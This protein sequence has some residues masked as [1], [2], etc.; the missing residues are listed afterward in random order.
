MNEGKASQENRTDSFQI[1]LSSITTNHIAAYPQSVFSTLVWLRR[2][3]E[4]LA[5]AVLVEEPANRAQI[6]CTIAEHLRLRGDGEKQQILPILAQV[7]ECLASLQEQRA[8][9]RIQ[10][11]LVEELVWWQQWLPAQEIADSTSNFWGRAWTFG[12]I[13]RQRLQAG[14]WEEAL[15]AASSAGESGHRWMFCSLC[16]ALARAHAWDD[17]EEVTRL[18]NHPGS[19]VKALSV[20]ARELT[21]ASYV[22]RAQ[23]LWRQAVLTAFEGGADVLVFGELSEELARAH[24]WELA[25]SVA[26][27]LTFPL[28]G[29]D[30]RAKQSGRML[31]QRAHE[32]IDA[33]WVPVVR[34]RALA[35]LA[36]EYTKAQRRA[37][38]EALWEEARA[39]ASS[40][41]IAWYQAEALSNLA[42]CFAEAG[43]CEFALDTWRQADGARKEARAQRHR[44]E[45]T[46][47]EQDGAN[48]SR[49]YDYEE[50]EQRLK[51]LL[52]FCRHLV[53]AQ[54]WKRAWEISCALEEASMKIRLGR[55][56]A[57]AL[58]QL[59]Q[60]EDAQMVWRHTSEV[61]LTT[62]LRVRDLAEL[63]LAL[64]RA[65]CGNE[66]D[67]VWKACVN[68]VLEAD[69]EQCAINGG[70][71]AL[72][73]AQAQRWEEAELML[74]ESMRAIVLLEEADL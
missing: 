64:Q 59:Q 28:P 4:A 10:A 72:K 38:A 44:M 37:D 36:R 73:L 58:D 71:L 49:I 42:I 25:E 69:L 63:A 9:S 62:R 67:A 57:T 21:V 34:S 45:K 65:Q 30:V 32:R 12:P 56:I 54:W 3:H 5:L 60:S 43:L 23:S 48:L 52:P 8:I 68:S 6:L 55:E 7:Q 20:L 41:D 39:V 24:Q 53:H 17:A 74:K 51:L 15:A 50:D 35:T 61:A 16:D 2:E 1:D 29:A 11:Y 46:S 70:S 40:I 47:V 19:K 27:A 14:M 13:F 33:R 66:A 31:N 18:M 26:R 22:E